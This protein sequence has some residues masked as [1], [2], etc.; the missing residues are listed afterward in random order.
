MSPRPSISC[1]V[2]CAVLLSPTPVRAGQADPDTVRILLGGHGYGLGGDLPS[3]GL[4][5]GADTL[6]TFG[7]QAYVAGGDAVNHGSAAQWDS[8]VK[9]IAPWGVDFLPVVGNHEANNRPE[10]VSRFGSSYR[11]HDVGSTRILVI[12]TVEYPNSRLSD[13]QATWFLNALH[14]AAADGTVER[15]IVAMH[16]LLWIKA[17]PRYD[18]LAL[19]GNASY[20]GFTNKGYDV[21]PFFDVFWP[22]ILALDAVKPVVYFAGDIGWNNT[23]PGLFHDELDGVTLLACG[24]APDGFPASDA[25]IL[26]EAAGD[27]VRFRSISPWGTD[28]GPVEQY[29]VEYW[30]D[31]YL[32]R[33]VCADLDSVLTGPGDAPVVE[34]PGGTF[35]MGD[36]FNEQ[37]LAYTAETGRSVTLLPFSVAAREVTVDEYVAFL[38]ARGNNDCSGG[39]CVDLD[40]PECPIEFAEGGFRA[41]TPG[42]GDHPVVEVTWPGAVEYCKYRTE[43][44][45]LEPAYDGTAVDLTKTGW[46]LP[47]D[48]EFEYAMRGGEGYLAGKTKYFRFPWM[49]DDHCQA[50][51][52]ANYHG[53]GGGDQWEGTA[54]VG[55]F[56]P[57]QYGIYDLSGNVFEWVQDPWADLVPGTFENPIGPASFLAGWRVLR[58]GGFNYSW[59]ACRNAYRSAEPAGDS[60]SYIGFRIAK[61]G[62]LV[63]VRVVRFHGVRRGPGR[64][65]LEWSMEYPPS[66]VAGFRLYRSVG[67]APRIRVGE[68]FFSG[69]AGYTFT[70]EEAPPGEVSYWLTE[71]SR[72]GGS[73]WHGPYRVGGEAA[74]AP[75]LAQNRPNPVHT[76]TELRFSLPRSGRAVLS[77][78]DLRGARIAVLFDEEA[79]PG[80]YELTWDGT[81]GAG[82]ALPSG[83]YFYRLATADGSLTR[84][85]ILHR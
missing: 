52:Y 9:L 8:L 61:T 25:L 19:F 16:H 64:I 83:I 66:Y 63:P 20:S 72:T 28:L 68:T 18:H 1:L 85:A 15:V 81:D 46:R 49:D 2:L 36:H 33:V 53:T 24:T 78:F 14:A 22:E 35:Q 82:R 69:S 11:S 56:P 73:T 60:Q 59:M 17:H 41:R 51:D 84:K 43:V 30:N 76:S 47:T 23:R 55:S 54:P 26:Y 75:A 38:Q 40:D 27:S 65:V 44:D 39:E 6:G 50:R 10:Y 45:G 57:N 5:A 74:V 70:D 29:G 31:W 62:G 77:V 13:D 3:L 67:D 34:L 12:D 4:L 7:A 21:N 71:L 42:A 48:A 58:G 32:S 80:H 79:G 37:N